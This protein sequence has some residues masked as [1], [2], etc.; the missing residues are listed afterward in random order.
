M[1]IMGTLKK[2]VP[3]ISTIAA[4]LWVE[5][6]PGWGTVKDKLDAK[7][8]DQAAQSFIAGMTGLRL[9]PIGGQMTTELDVFGTLNPVDFRNAPYPKVALWSRLSMEGID[10]I[11][12]FVRGLFADLKKGS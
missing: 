8:Y 12:G 11:G 2:I 7:Q 3:M 9:G 5:P 1:S 4:V 10:T 6:S